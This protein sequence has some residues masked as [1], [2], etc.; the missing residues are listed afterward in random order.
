MMKRFVNILGET[1]KAQLNKVDSI[2]SQS[3]EN[4]NHIKKRTSNIVERSHSAVQNVKKQGYEIQD[5]ASNIIE[6]GQ[7]TVENVRK[8]GYKITKE[9]SATLEQPLKYGVKYGEDVV[10]NSVKETVSYAENKA[11]DSFKQLKRFTFTAIFIGCFA[12]GFGKE[13]PKLIHKEYK[14]WKGNS[15]N[16]SSDNNNVSVDN[17]KIVDNNKNN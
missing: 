11:K 16:L 2:K 7:S 14:D 3:I 13:L 9:A 10:K 8:Q 1:L 6:R 17:N 5:K 15:A 4:V 12:Y